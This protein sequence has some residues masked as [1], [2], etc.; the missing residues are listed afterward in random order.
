MYFAWYINTLF[1]F[2]LLKYFYF[3]DREELMGLTQQRHNGCCM[4][5]FGRCGNLVDIITYT[6]GLYAKKWKD[7]LCLWLY[8]KG[9]PED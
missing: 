6:K 3:S 1:L 9:I 7:S 8:L 4:D 2:S 5:K